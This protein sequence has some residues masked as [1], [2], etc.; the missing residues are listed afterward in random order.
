[1]QKKHYF[2]K[3]LLKCYFQMLFMPVKHLLLKGLI[4]LSD[5]FQIILAF[6]ILIYIFF[7]LFHLK[8]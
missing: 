4:I 6:F 2:I 3:N 8:K 7:I 1:M 5:H